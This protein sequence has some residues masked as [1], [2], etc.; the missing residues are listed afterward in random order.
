[1]KV[2]LVIPAH[3]EEAFIGGC[4]D[5]VLANAAGK[6]HEIVVVDNAS[7]DRTAEI[8]ATRPGVRVVL[9]PD[10][11]LTKARQRGYLETTGEFVA[12][13][14]ADTRMPPGWFERAERTFAARPEAVSLS[15]PPR[16][17][18]ATRLQRA[19]LSSVW[20]STAP[21]AYRMVG[22]MLYGAHFVVRRSALDRIAG[23]DRDVE[24]YG[25]DTDLARRLSPHGRVLF[26]MRFVIG[27]SARRFIKEGIVRTNFTYLMNFVWPVVFGRPFTKTHTDV[28]PDLPTP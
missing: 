22:Y 1:M 12:Y 15:G 28:R 7:S 14:D 24:F 27:S 9:E 18:D 16:Y 20:W 25:E 10:K 3:N 17:W 26:D 5:A 2:S 6:F 4:L 8:A 21:V 23:F 13:I 19:V 11:G